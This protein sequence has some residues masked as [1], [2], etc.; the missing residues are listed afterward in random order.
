MGSAETSVP[1]LDESVLSELRTLGA[2]V[3]AE[4][5][6][7]FVADVP[8]RLAKLQQAID[9]R[10]REGVLREAH[11]LKGSALGIGASRFASLCA[12]IEHDAREGHLDQATLRA[13][14][15]EG[16]FAEVRIVLRELGVSGGLS[17]SQA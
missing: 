12:V 2:D 3:V 15:L 6:A 17:D 9:D 8:S 4:I 14:K 13:S 11:G 7:L 5:F 16:E 10:S 1:V